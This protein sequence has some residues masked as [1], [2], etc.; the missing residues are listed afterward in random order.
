MGD[1]LRFFDAALGTDVRDDPLDKLVIP[2]DRCQGFAGIILS[3]VLQR[4][5]NGDAAL[6]EPPPTVFRRL[7][8]PQG[9]QSGVVA[10]YQ[11][12]IESNRTPDGAGPGRLPV[13]TAL[14]QIAYEDEPEKL[15]A[16]PR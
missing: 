14:V 4:T 11:R 12:G 5:R 6:G 15:E 1:D 3:L 7:K 16:A 9:C 8:E 2:E 13:V 10:G